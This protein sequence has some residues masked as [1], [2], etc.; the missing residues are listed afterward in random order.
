MGACPQT[1]VDVSPRI[2]FWGASSVLRV[3]MC[4]STLGVEST[5][6]EI[7]V[8]TSFNFYVFT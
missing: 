7:N 3:G 5:D 8:Q 6:L 4:V 1:P 2:K